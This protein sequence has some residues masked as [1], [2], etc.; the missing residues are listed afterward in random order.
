MTNKVK[1]LVSI[2]SDT[3]T[4]EK[5]E[6]V[7]NLRKITKV[8]LIPPAKFGACPTFP[9]CQKKKWTKTF[10]M[11][12]YFLQIKDEYAEE[13]KRLHKECEQEKTKSHELAK[14][15]RRIQS[16]GTKNST[17]IS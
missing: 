6:L 9:I 16:G 15:L 12:P 4:R 5:T 17:S 14:E 7:V 13:I 11:I 1:D 2:L 8:C 3:E 10:F